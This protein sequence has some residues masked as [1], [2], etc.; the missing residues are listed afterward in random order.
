MGRRVFFSEIS[1]GF[2]DS[3]YET[4]IYFIADEKLS[5]EFA[6]DAAG[7]SSE[8]RTIQRSDWP[9]LWGDTHGIRVAAGTANC[10]TSQAYGNRLRSGSVS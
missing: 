6:G 9:R 8:E 5:E 4:E 2:D 3:G 1:F 10:K 7:I